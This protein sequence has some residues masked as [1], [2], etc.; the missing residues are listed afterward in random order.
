MGLTSKLLQLMI[1]MMMIQSGD[2]D[3]DGVNRVFIMSSRRMIS[4]RRM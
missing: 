2:Y 4:W 1:M 3:G